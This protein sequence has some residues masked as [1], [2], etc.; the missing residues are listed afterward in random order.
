MNYAVRFGKQFSER[1]PFLALSSRRGTPVK[2]LDN[3]LQSLLFS[4]LT[5]KTRENSAGMQAVKHFCYTRD[6]PLAKSF[7]C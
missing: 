3:N 1:F 2:L 7:R 5:R 6:M 4:S